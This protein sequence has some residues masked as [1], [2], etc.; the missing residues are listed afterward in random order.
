MN[1]QQRLRFM[2]RALN[3][4]ARGAG[5]V[6]PNPKVGAVIVKQDQII[7][8]GYHRR[9]GLAHAEVEALQNCRNRGENPS[10][11]TMFVTLEPCCHQGK[12]GPCT[13]AIATAGISHV[14]IATLDDCELVAGKG[15]VWLREKG[16]SVNTGYC[17]HQ[18]RRLNTGFF[19]HQKTGLPQ[20]ILK[21]AQSIDAKLTW[22]SPSQ[23]RWI[24]NE[25]SR[26]HV[27]RLRHQCGAVLVGIGTVLADDPLLTVRLGR[28][29]YQPRLERQNSKE[30]K[31]NER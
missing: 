4:A 2:K 31:D 25:N 8:S 10:G 7:G 26:R 21:W 20:V 27:H 9:Y 23:K 17:E 22:P 15:A 5:W 13:E 29:S 11:A 12:T 1:D 14:E 18:A 24:T 30:F 3:L 16:I 28:K 6:A 19:K